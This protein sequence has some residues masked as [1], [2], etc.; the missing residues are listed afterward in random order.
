M[1][2]GLISKMSLE[3]LKNH[4]RIR[5]FK[6]NGRKKELVARENNF[7]ASENSVK[8]IKTTV[9]VEADFKNRVF[10]QTEN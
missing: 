7:A 2:P 3:E 8:P 4:L 6:V 10:S 5:G 9:E 1:D